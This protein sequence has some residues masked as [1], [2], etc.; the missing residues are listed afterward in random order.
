MQ[1]DFGKMGS[2]LELGD[3]LGA[4]PGTKGGQG[5]CVRLSAERSLGEICREIMKNKGKVKNAEARKADYEEKFRTR[6]GRKE[7]EE[8]VG[9]RQGEAGRR[10]EGGG[11]RR[12]T[13][14]RRKQ[15]RGSSRWEKGG[16]RK[17]KER[18]RKKREEDERGGK[19]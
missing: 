17:E 2:R 7:G 10:K 11:R 18:G 9:R 13:G 8:E 5:C 14:G 3:V 6:R 1:R 12:E 19:T 4:T 15:A 16:G